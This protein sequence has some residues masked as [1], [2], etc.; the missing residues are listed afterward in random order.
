M[1]LRPA[2]YTPGR[3]AGGLAAQAL[4]DL[5][6]GRRVTADRRAV[7]RELR[8]VGVL[9]AGRASPVGRKGG[10]GRT[11]GAPRRGKGHADVSIRR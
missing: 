5:A 1:N 2:G 7:L 8:D 4:L 10:A 3:T 11:S 6:E 9:P